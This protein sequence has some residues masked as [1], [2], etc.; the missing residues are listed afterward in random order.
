MTHSVYMNILNDC[1]KKKTTFV[2]SEKVQMIPTSQRNRYFRKGLVN[3][4]CTHVQE[5]KKAMLQRHSACIP[6]NV[7]SP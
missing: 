3:I 4:T 2:R 7:K 1:F 6:S 5:Q